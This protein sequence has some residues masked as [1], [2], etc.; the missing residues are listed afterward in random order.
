[1]GWHVACFP[2]RAVLRL[3]GMTSRAGAPTLQNVPSAG[4]DWSF[5]DNATRRCLDALDRSPNTKAGLVIPT[6]GGKT[7]TALRIGIQFAKRH[8]VGNIVWVTHRR[9]LRDQAQQEFQDLLNDGAVSPEDARI[10]S[11]RMEFLMLGEL[12]A[13]LADASKPPALLIVDEAHHAAAA[14]YAPIFETSYALP[15]L[16]LTA[17]PNRTDDLPIGIDTI[18]YSITYRDLAKRGVVIIPEF[19]ELP[20]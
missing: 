9:D 18:A 16:F 2:A 11:D 17:T 6:A 10:I 13:R 8:G 12:A 1:M 15:A 14:S 7:R 19:D 3:E 4:P 5:Q 20:V